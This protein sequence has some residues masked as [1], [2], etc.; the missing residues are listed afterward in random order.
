M[1]GAI[2]VAALVGLASLLAGVLLG[3]HLRRTNNWCPGCG[4][5][6]ACTACGEPATRPH[7][8]EPAGSR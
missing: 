4:D 3:W 6:L 2:A 8:P 7:D 1:I 5:Q